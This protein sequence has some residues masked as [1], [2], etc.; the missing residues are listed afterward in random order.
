LR[1]AAS[2]A[3]L[4]VLAWRTDW[5]QVRAA[6]ASLRLDLWILAVAIYA[7]TQAASSLRWQLL[8]RPL[9]FHAPFGRFFSLYYIGMFFNLVLPTSVGGDVVRAWYLD[10]KSGR[11]ADAFISVIADRVSGVV[12]LLLIALVALAFQPADLPAWVTWT[13]AAMTGGALLLLGLLFLFSRGQIANCKLQIANCELDGSWRGRLR[14]LQFAICNLQ[15]AIFPSRAVFVLSTLLSIVVQLANVL[16]V[17]LIGQALGLPVPAAYYLVLVPTVTLLTLLPISLNGMGVREGGMAVLLAP[18]G[19][20]TGPAMTLAFLWFVAFMVPS[21]G[22]VF[23]YW[24][25]GLPRF[26]EG[27]DDQSLGGGSDQGRTGQ[28]RPIVRAIADGARAAGR[29]V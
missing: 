16:I 5:E 24:W 29:P 7:A 26:T 12:V 18:L 19:V 11:R 25:G 13:V 6:F 17:W 9:G 22:G 8:A 1:L 15:F 3:L 14:N 20:E 4:G 28:S 10:N 21:L 2:G 23:F 27:S